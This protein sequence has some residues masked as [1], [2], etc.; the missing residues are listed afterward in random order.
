MMKKHF[1]YSVPLALSLLLSGCAQADPMSS[2]SHPPI[3][4]SAWVAAWDMESG[5]KEYKKLHRHLDSM[6]CF[7]VHYGKDD[8][9]VI[10]EETRQIAALAKKSGQKQR[11]LT[12]DNDWEDGTGT[13][14]LKDVEL[15]KR[16]LADDEAKDRTIRDIIAAAKELDCTGVELDYEAFWKDEKLLQDYLSFTYLLSSACLKEGLPLRIV[17]EPGMPMDAGLC[18]GPEYVVM[19]YNLYGKHSGPGPKADRD[20]IAK[21]VKKMEAIP[22]KKGAAFATGGCIWEDYG[23]LG[24]SKGP[25]RFIDEEEAAALAKAHQATLERDADSAALHF[26]FEENGK[27]CEV[28]YADSET[29]NAWIKAAADAGIENIS[30]WRLGHNVDIRKV[31]AK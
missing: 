23:L 30:L 31:D 14:R 9:L 2:G 1:L 26:T 18:K 17:L 3:R 20:F 11:Y 4:L 22:G 13:A 29:L 7:A 16:L 6:S 5:A 28:W 19:F 24:L 15:M 25:I 10:P 8:R 27:S 12:F 21:T